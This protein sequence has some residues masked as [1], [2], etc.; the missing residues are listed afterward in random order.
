MTQPGNT[1]D[2]R[3]VKMNYPK[4]FTGNRNETKRFMQDCDLYLTINDKIYDT[5]MKK[6][7]FVTAL[8]NDGDAASWKEQFIEN[9]IVTSGANN[10]PLTLG[11][12]LAFKHDLHEAFT[13]YDAPGDALEKMKNLRMKSDDS[14]DDH[15]AKFKML[16]TS[17]GLSTSAA[18]IDLYRESLPNAL[19]RR[20]LFLEKPP[21]TMDGWYEWS[22][23]LHHQWKRMQR[24]LG[25][26][27]RT[28]PK[29]QNN[30]GGRKF[31][32]TR[33]NRDP[34]AMDIDALTYEERGTLMKEGKCFNC[35]NV[36]HLAKDCPK[37][38]K[39]KK[40][41]G[42][43]ELHAHIRGLMKDMDE[44]EKE[45]FLNEAEEAGF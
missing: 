33:Q 17:S 12:F 22:T 43:K 40:K 16:V 27:T 45:M 1:N 14:I 24:I 19:Q 32:F 23:R 5:D 7:G 13:P 6:I 15:V 9:C 39:Q 34:D 38:D 2:A 42:G 29:K 41:I 30:N 35:R 8:M 28:T 25:R 3:E 21:T 11:T 26:E 37:K 44:N 10:T 20:I 36:G 4:T 18:I 31:H